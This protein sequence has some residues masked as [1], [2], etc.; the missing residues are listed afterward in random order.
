[1]K[2]IHF[3]YAALL[4]AVASLTSCDDPAAPPVLPTTN[5]EDNL[6]MGNPSNAT[7]NDNS[8]YLIVKPQYVLSYNE[9]TQ[10]A[11]WVAWHL[12][13]DWKGTAT[14]QNVFKPDPDLPTNFWHVTT[15][16]YTN[17]NFDRG[18]LCPSDDRD[19]TQADN[20]ATF[21]LSNIIPQNPTLNRQTWA[22][23]EEYTRTLVSQGNECYIIAGPQG[24]GGQNGLT[25]DNAYYG[26][27]ESGHVRIPEFCWKAILVLPVGQNDLTRVV[28]NSRLIGVIMPNEKTVNAHAWGYYRVKVRDIETLTGF[29]FFSKL[30]QSTQNAIE[31]RIDTGPTQ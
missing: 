12:S 20:D 9:S 18:H 19:G 10:T 24:Q 3:I 13:S 22:Y 28:T 5:K 30:P 1:M 21:Y 8:N 26:A 4:F 14:R 29:N 11:N 25:G 31:N 16:T 6:G 23:L 15:N 7:V 27:L 17:T 2:K